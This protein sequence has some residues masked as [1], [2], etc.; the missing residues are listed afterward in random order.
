M[1]K[2]VTIAIIILFTAGGLMMTTRKQRM[3]VCFEKFQTTSNFQP[4][5]R[6][7]ERAKPIMHSKLLPYILNSYRNESDI[8]FTV[9]MIGLCTSHEDNDTLRAF[10]R[11]PSTAQQ[12]RIICMAQLFSRG[13]IDILGDVTDEDIEMI[14][15]SMPVH[16]IHWK[17][18]LVHYSGRPR[19]CLYNDPLPERRRFK[20]LFRD[21]IELHD[22]KE[23]KKRLLEK[24]AAS[25]M[26]NLAES[27]TEPAT[28]VKLN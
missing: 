11:D 17:Q 19:S 15:S 18:L 12:V 3:A 2:W 20:A 5:R 14:A 7:I 25:S 26:Q 22:I 8:Q 13:Y 24:K 21:C 4:R 16:I 10:A 1:T 23:A 9:A 27:T 6:I 28:P